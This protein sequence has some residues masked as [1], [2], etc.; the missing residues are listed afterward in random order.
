MKSKLGGV[1]SI[2]C[3]KSVWLLVKEI[4]FTST[5]PT[6]E[7]NQPSKIKPALVGS[8]NTFTDKEYP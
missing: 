5:P 2:H 6:D 4:V 3:A 7:S 8:E 1:I